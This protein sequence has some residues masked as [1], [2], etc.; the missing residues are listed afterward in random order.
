MPKHYLLEEPDPQK[1]KPAGEPALIQRWCI[2]RRYGADPLNPHLIIEVAEATPALQETLA[3]LPGSE[4]RSLAERLA[5]LEQDNLDW[6]QESSERIHESQAD[7]LKRLTEPE[8]FFKG[9]PPDSWSIEEGMVFLHLNEAGGTLVPFT[10]QARQMSKDLYRDLTGM[11]PEA[12]ST[13]AKK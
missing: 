13:S 12:G 11:K 5:G 7:F 2:I 8:K 1:R 9:M 4:T 10:Y 6:W 3:A